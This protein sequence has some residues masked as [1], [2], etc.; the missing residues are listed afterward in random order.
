VRSAKRLAIQKPSK[1]ARL[2]KS[3]MRV[4]VGSSFASSAVLGLSPIQRMSLSPNSGFQRW[5]RL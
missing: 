2:E 1:P 3:A 5:I 4:R